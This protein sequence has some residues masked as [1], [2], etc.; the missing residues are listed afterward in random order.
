MSA[1]RLQPEPAYSGMLMTFL[2]G[3]RPPPG[4]GAS[5]LAGPR[6]CRPLRGAGTWCPEPDGKQ[7]AAAGFPQTGRDRVEFAR[8][9]SEPCEGRAGPFETR[10]AEAP[11]QLLRA[12][13]DDCTADG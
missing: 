6:G 10:A 11:E 5:D 3:F 9:E 8:A 1:S 13:G 12:V 7:G 4:R 2:I